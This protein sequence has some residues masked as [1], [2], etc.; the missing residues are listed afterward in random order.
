M[1][2]G[3]TTT[4]TL[5][6]SLLR[7]LP[8]G[9]LTLAAL[10]QRYR[11]RRSVKE[12]RPPDDAPLPIPAPHVSII[13][14]V[15]NEEA[16]IDACLASLL[17]QDYPDFNITI[18]DDGSTDATPRLLAE[19]KTRDQRI[20]VHRLDILP[21]GWAGK[22]H[23][24]HTGVLLTNGEWLLFTDADTHHAPQTLRLMVGHALR[25]HDDLLSMS[26]NLMTIA[27][28]TMS[29][30]MPTSEAVLALRVTPAE[31]KDPAFPHAFAFGQYI[32]L[33]REAYLA[34][35]GYAV[36]GMRS[37]SI[38]DLAL[39]EQFKQ[40]RLSVEVVNGRGLIEN[41]QWTTW[42][43]ASQGWRKSCY[44]ELVRSRVPLGGLPAALVLI[45]YGLGPLFTLLYAFCSGKVRRSSTL[46]AG[47]SLLAQI[48][49]KR[50]ID[51]EY[52]LA[53][54][55]SLA[56]P[57]GWVVFGIQVLA[58]AYLILTGRGTDWKGR[59]LPKQEIAPSYSHRNILPPSLRG[60]FS[61]QRA[62]KK[63]RSH[64]GLFTHSLQQKSRSRT[65]A[66]HIDTEKV[67]SE[68]AS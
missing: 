39:A 18:I 21:A 49:A 59:K 15:R 28:P 68:K 46:L 10:W 32:L 54:R 62:I 3:R 50:C 7:Y 6:N 56:A 23:A 40:H 41:R 33:R 27:G 64:T 53:F 17:A 8:L 58:V 47:I 5:M 60:N 22:A 4:G 63:R 37:T 67:D 31:V 25:Q 29:L 55:W 11:A 1:N 43:S 44:G 36:T 66:P 14:P 42:K 24:L 26:T 30:L 48:D 13:L 52:D 16:N 61:G 35:G 51:R 38:D 45:A 2:S 57:A 19:W 20:Q 12:T 34:T 9:A 65:R